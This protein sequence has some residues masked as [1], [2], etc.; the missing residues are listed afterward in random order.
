MNDENIKNI[1]VE[2][3]KRLLFGFQITQRYTL[4]R[5]SE[6]EIRNILVKVVEE[7]N[8]HYALEVPTVEP[9]VHDARGVTRKALVDLVLYDETDENKALYLEL[10]IGQPNEEKI[11]KDIKKM[12]GDRERIKGG[13]FFHYLNK[14]EI[15]NR[16]K[17]AKESILNKYRKSLEK[18]CNKP[19]YRE[20]K[21]DDC[22]FTLF[23]LDGTEEDYYYCHVSSMRDN[24]D[25]FL[26]WKK[27]EE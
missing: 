20:I 13:I 25:I 14:S 8:I 23:I 2:T 16:H 3:S 19:E 21:I 11:I 26:N 12:I 1:L 6:H 15:T 17:H 9:Y 10:K 18:A 27:I 7:N 5:M 4:E 24:L 22:S